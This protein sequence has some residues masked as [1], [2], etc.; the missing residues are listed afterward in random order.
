MPRMHVVT[1]AILLG[2]PLAALAQPGSAVNSAEPFKVGTFVSG[3]TRTTGMVL[4][5]VQ[6]RTRTPSRTTR[7]T[8]NPSVLPTV[9]ASSTAVFP[10]AAT[11]LIK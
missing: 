5:P 9:S 6:N 2:V 4:L 11:P 8:E 10:F 3:N 7:P 1:L